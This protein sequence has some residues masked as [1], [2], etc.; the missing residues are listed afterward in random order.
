MPTTARRVV[1][2]VAFAA[3]IA[4]A[5][6]R[7][8]WRDVGVNVYGL[9]YHVDRDRARELDVDNGLNPGLGVRYNFA[10]WERWTF[11]AEAGAYHDSGRNTAVYGGAA[12]LW[13]AVG[14]LHVGAALVAMNSDTYNRGKTFLAPLPVIGYDFGP[15]MV[16][17][18]YFPKV[19]N[20]NEVGTLGLWFTLWPGRW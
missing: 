15:A 6:A 11:L 14:G 12:A 9:S 10:K 2:A 7:A 13:Q 19:S 16:N 8:D 3:C 18:T 1:L 4:A 17:L 5:P 20:Y